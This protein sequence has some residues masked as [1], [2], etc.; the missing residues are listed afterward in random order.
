MT[1]CAFGLARIVRDGARVECGRVHVEAGSGMHDVAD[2]ESD[3][4]R[5]RRDDFE[6]EKSFASDAADLAQIVHPGD[7]GDHG[8]EDH[9]SDDHGDQSDEGVAQRFHRDSFRGADVAE[10]DRDQDGETHLHPE[11]CVKVLR[12]RGGSVGLGRRDLSRHK[13]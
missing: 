6:I 7:S 8:A 1:V 3:D 11:R 5:Q 4:Q 9:Q 10:D 2:D 12:G 13:I